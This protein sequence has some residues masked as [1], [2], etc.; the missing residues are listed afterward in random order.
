MREIVWLLRVQLL[1]LGGFNKT[2]YAAD[3]AEKHRSRLLLAG[4][5]SVVLLLVAMSAMYAFGLATLL[6]AAG[7]LALLPPLLMAVACLL[8]LVTTLL[9][10]A[11]TLFAFRDYD[12][13]M[14]LPVRTSCIVAS[15]L[16]LLY[17]MNFA[18]T[19][20]VMVPG[21]VAYAVF[22]APGPLYYLYFL[23]TLPVIPLVPL[24]L[25]T[26][27][28]TVAG[29]AAS[30]FRHKSQATILLS[31]LFA[32]AVVVG[33]FF[34]GDQTQAD[35]AD[36]GRMLAQ[37]VGQ[38]YP[39]APLYGRAVCEGS[40]VA[41]LLFLVPS[42]LLFAAFCAV[43]GRY[44]RKWH[45]LLTVGRAPARFR[46]DALRTASPLA[47]LFRKE[48]KRYISSALYVTNTFIGMVLLT[49]ASIALLVFGRDKAAQVLEL[50]FAA[51]RLAVMI[52]PAMCFFIGL[53]VTTAS[54]ISL[55]GPHIVGLRALPV[56]A[57][58][59]FLSK[60]AVSLVTTVPLTLVNSALFATAMRP[61]LWSGVLF[62]LLPC[63]FA[64]FAS[65][66]GLCLNLAFPNFSWTTEAQ[67]IKQSAATMAQVFGCMGL[68]VAF[69][70]LTALAGPSANWALTG[71]TA[72]LVAGSAVLYRYLL[73][74][75]AK[76]L[77]AL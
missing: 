47:A 1:A 73:G 36:I 61:G 67:V 45:G 52:P 51:D 37:A 43:T 48:W 65:L 3:P 30:R 11:G 77:Y 28:G 29:L 59:I 16:L 12:A 42:L 17:G 68:T 74:R 23:L 70:V 76:K 39:L 7:Q 72:L 21:G 54:S 19:C 71:L 26:I 49:A 4:M 40:P 38:I 69:V 75:G 64:V 34:L 63:A 46:F 56:T 9:K 31:L 15:R 14:S 20:L 62:F 2:R 8:S 66:M 44:F 32:V 35:L 25:A 41:L 18:F 22:A 55:E 50:P 6:Y 27:L 5:V 53:S 13:Q 33:P 60:L 10:A 58:E 57:R 24:I